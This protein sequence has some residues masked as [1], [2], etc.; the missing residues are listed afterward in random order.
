MC[1]YLKKL[2][3]GAFQWCD[4]ENTATGNSLNFPEPHNSGPPW[5]GSRYKRQRAQCLMSSG[6]DGRHPGWK[7]EEGL[8]PRPLGPSLAQGGQRPADS[9]FLKPWKQQNLGSAP[10]VQVSH[11]AHSCF[12]HASGILL[13]PVMSTGPSFPRENTHPV[14]ERPNQRPILTLNAYLGSLRLTALL[15]F[16]GWEK[17]K[18][19]NIHWAPTMCQIMCDHVMYALFL[20]LTTPT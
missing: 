3:T 8:C 13:F 16:G 5:R 4:V 12:F 20:N 15:G 10:H 19:T 14:A 7:M 11:P 2:A 1:P 9:I 17:G 6:Q 18:R